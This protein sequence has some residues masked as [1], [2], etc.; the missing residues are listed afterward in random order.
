MPLVVKPGAKQK[1]TLRGKGLAAVKEVT[2]AG[3][4]GI[5]QGSRPKAVGVPNNY[6]AERIGDSEVE[7]ELELPKDVKLGL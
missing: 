4:R 2:I 5:S 1:L 3:G 7:I 6:P